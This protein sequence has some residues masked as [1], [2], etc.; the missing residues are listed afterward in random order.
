MNLAI[1]IVVVNDT[2]YNDVPVTTKQ[3]TATFDGAPVSMT[4]CE[5]GAVADAT[6][7]ANFGVLSQSRAGNPVPDV[8][9]DDVGFRHS[10]GTPAFRTVENKVFHALAAQALGTLLPE[11]PTNGI[12]DVALATAVGSHYRRNSGFQSYLSFFSKGLKPH[13]VQPFNVQNHSSLIWSR[14]W[15]VWYHSHIGM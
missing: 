5:D 9:N 12:H 11:Y 8:C 3:L 1:T 14:I 6:A 15:P 2:D 7:K 10:T 4:H 13:Q